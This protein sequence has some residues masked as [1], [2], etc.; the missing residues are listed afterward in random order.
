M[1]ATSTK[2]DGCA[3]G[4]TGKN[5]SPQWETRNVTPPLAPPA[6][7]HSDYKKQ[8]KAAKATGHIQVRGGARL[9]CMLNV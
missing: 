4:Q 6:R 3:R 7:S 8:M 5:P 2:T 9:T 1:H